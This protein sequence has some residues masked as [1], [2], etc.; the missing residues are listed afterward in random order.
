MAPDRSRWRIAAAIALAVLGA[1][2]A[3]SLWPGGGEDGEHTAPRSAAPCP[4]RFVDHPGREHTI[5]G[6]L[7]STDEGRRI[8]RETESIAVRFCFGEIRVPVVMTEGNV[9]M[10]DASDGDASLA[11][12]AGHLLDHVAHGSPFPERL[13]RG[14]DCD[15]VVR[16][17]LHAEARA[18][19]LEL[20]LRRALGPLEV[21]YEFERDFFSRGERAIYDYFV[22]HPNG[23]PAV[24]PLAS[25][26]RQRCETESR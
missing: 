23:G 12:R 10:L 24:D 11:A 13:E 7:G 6:L 2:V 4:E 22:S 14:A 1:G 25:A 18:Y 17:A 5:R 19:A 16:R 26:Y 9:L 20:R 15:Q 3:Y 8:L 21:R